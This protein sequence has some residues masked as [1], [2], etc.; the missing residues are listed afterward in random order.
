MVGQ[1]LAAPNTKGIAA[2]ALLSPNGLDV[3]RYKTQTLFQA[4]EVPPPAPLSR[5]KYRVLKL[6]VGTRGCQRNGALCCRLPRTFR[7]AAHEVS[8]PQ[9]YPLILPW[10]P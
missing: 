5:C 4:E 10:R 9:M 1:C 3:I 8:F 2:D 7:R 6:S